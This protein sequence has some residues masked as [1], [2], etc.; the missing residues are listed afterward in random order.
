[1]KSEKVKEVASEIMKC[2]L[3][4]AALVKRSLPLEVISPQ[5]NP[6]LGLHQEKGPF[7]L[8]KL[9]IQSKHLSGYSGQRSIRGN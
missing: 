9:G 2:T 4:K 8:W 7:I 5:L 6:L 3:I 1:V